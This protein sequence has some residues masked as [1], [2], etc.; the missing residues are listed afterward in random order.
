MPI[1]DWSR[2]SAGTF[3]AFQSLAAT[4]DESKKT[5][6]A[7]ESGLL[8]ARHP[9]TPWFEPA[10][11]RYTW[12]WLTAQCGADVSAPSLREVQF[13][14]SKTYF[15]RLDRDGDGRITPGDLDWSERN[16]W[17]QQSYLVNRLFRWK[18]ICTRRQADAHL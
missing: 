8:P 9:T 13:Y 3:H 15:K 12:K 16:P 14:G 2:V 7:N 6:A 10:E 4:A 17:V 18:K 5:Y 11:T 1:H